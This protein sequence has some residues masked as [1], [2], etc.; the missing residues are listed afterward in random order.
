[1]NAARPPSSAP[2]REPRDDERLSSW[3]EI[4]A[5]LGRDVRTVQR[6]ERTQG[7]PV[8]RHQ[9]HRLTTAYAYR[10]ELDA[11]WRNEEGRGHAPDGSRDPQEPA[12]TPIEPVQEAAPGSS[13]V[14][15]GGMQTRHLMLAVTV[16]LTAIVGLL[17]GQIASGGGTLPANPGGETWSL[18]TAVDNRTGEEIWTGTI[19]HLLRQHLAGSP[20]VRLASSD[21]VR[22][23]LRLM[24]RPPDVVLDPATARELC[25]RD[26]DIRILIASRLDRFGSRYE[27]AIDLIA[28]LD[29]RVIASRRL[30]AVQ[31]DH[32]P[33]LIGDHARWIQ[34]AL[35][36][37]ARTL[38]QPPRTERVSTRSFEALQLYTKANELGL[39][40]QWAAAAKLLEARNGT[41]SRRVT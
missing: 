6:W 34:Q 38:A 19:E 25:L 32:L 13:T 35:G 28:P 33:S 14:A 17:V 29:G 39:Q 11:W 18:V 9:H 4:A 40:G 12:S 7:L 37:N 24:Q 10:S 15:P 5:Y 20:V 21:R 3:K 26:G 31:P 16:V 23:A 41:S 8:R 36:A 2:A 30:S 22:D 27:L 1:M